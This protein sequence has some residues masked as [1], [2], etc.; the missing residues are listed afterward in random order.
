MERVYKLM[1]RT[2]TCPECRKRAFDIKK[3]PDANIEVALKCPHCK[4]IIT[5]KV[6][7]I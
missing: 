1:K 2:V 3:P 5:V 7:E 4:K 6:Y